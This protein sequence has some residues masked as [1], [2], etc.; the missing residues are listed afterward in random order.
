MP[1]QPGPQ[2]TLSA[3]DV[4]VMTLPVLAALAT[5]FLSLW[6]D[7]NKRGLDS[8]SDESTEATGAWKRIGASGW[9]LIALAAVT[10]VTGL[11]SGFKDLRDA[12]ARSEENAALRN[13]LSDTKVTLGKQLADSLKETSNA[14]N[15]TIAETQ[16]SAEKL[17]KIADT[18]ATELQKQQELTFVSLLSSVSEPA[19]AIVELD[20]QHAIPPDW[21]IGTRSN[22]AQMMA[23]A[24]DDNW[25]YSLLFEP[26]FRFIKWTD[27][28]PMN[29]ET[30]VG[31]WP[32]HNG[33][34]DTRRWGAGVAVTDRTKPKPNIPLRGSMEVRQD[35]H[36]IIR[37]PRLDGQSMI[38]LWRGPDVRSPVLL[39]WVQLNDVD[40]ETTLH[41]IE[42]LAS[43]EIIKATAYY[44][45]SAKATWCKRAALNVYDVHAAP[46]Q[47]HIRY[48]GT[49]KFDNVACPSYV[50]SPQEL[51]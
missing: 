25:R 16:A 19:Y 13:E 51:Y 30:W 49:D 1:L 11:Y 45:V 35:R 7:S 29:F 8:L 46:N 28:M 44:T 10:C 12:A 40:D 6:R 41:R 47:L 5:A 39:I 23:Q 31:D 21:K 15:A 24:H 17:K 42:A 50:I 36:L 22:I 34:N 48:F 43:K 3:F 4:V 26:L 27:P 32:T 20:L 37:F 2:H 33:T 14:K 9:T 18:H 38:D